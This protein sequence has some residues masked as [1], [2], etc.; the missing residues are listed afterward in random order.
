MEALIVFL[1]IWLLIIWIVTEKARAKHRTRL[2]WGVG[3]ALFGA[4]ALFLI[5]ILPPI[6]RQ[7]MTET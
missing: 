3:A 5:F 2:G 4:L 6:E 7:R 1:V